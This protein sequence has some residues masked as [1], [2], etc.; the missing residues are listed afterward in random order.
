[1]AT[2]IKAGIRQQAVR[3]TKVVGDGDGR[4]DVM[5][6]VDSLLLVAEVGTSLYLYHMQLEMSAS[7]LQLRE[8]LVTPFCPAS[9]LCSLLT[10]G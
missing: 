10:M 7:T 5:F 2:S 4:N 6:V 9:I 1:M 3:T 8:L